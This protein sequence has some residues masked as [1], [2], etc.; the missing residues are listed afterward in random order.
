MSEKVL[1]HADADQLTEDAAEKLVQRITKLQEDPERV[2]QLCLTGGRIA[3]KLYI[4]LAALA[5]RIDT[6]RV[7]FWW[8]DERFVATDDPDRNALQ[9]LVVLGGA[10]SFN[11]ALVHPMPAADGSPDLTSLLAAA[12]GYAEELGDT[13]FDICL[14]GIGP[15]GHVA[16]IFPD[17]PSFEK[18]TSRVIGVRNSPKPPPERVSLTI[19]V[20]NESTEV[21]FVASGAEKAEAVARSVAG[22]PTVPAG[23]VRGR[24]RTRWWVDAESAAQLPA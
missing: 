11:P 14:L 17:H 16:S 7:E 8:G 5:D 10:V 24:S 20:L 2:V 13:V 12:T 3:N 23:V 1:R 6:A 19:P 15:D 22:D 18:S 21:W 4:K 9:T